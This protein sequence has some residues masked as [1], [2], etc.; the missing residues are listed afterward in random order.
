[1]RSRT[2]G[3]DTGFLVLTPLRTSGATVLVVRGFVAAP[4]AGGIP[5]PA[6]PPGGTVTIT[7]RARDPETRHDTAALLTAHQ[8]ES[9]NPSE[10][11]PRLGGPVYNG[12]LQLE[13]GQPGTRGV[14]A[15]GNPDL[16]NPAG[17][18]LEPQHFAYVIQ[19]YLFAALALAAPVVMARSE[20]KQRRT[21][22][23]DPDHDPRDDANEAHDDGTD[24]PAPEPVTAPDP[25]V[26]AE[27]ARAAKL[28]D[29]YGQ[30]GA[31]MSG[32][33]R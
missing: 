24:V 18:A 3:D 30:H 27:E 33:P 4:A 7:A 22:D 15:L 21:G 17:G 25:E 8:V 26:G 13:D 28:A 19:W 1:M 9:I 23:I 5:T 29:R 16:S 6:P 11:A 2:D 10:Q 31:P 14:R 20:T 12:Y 32:G